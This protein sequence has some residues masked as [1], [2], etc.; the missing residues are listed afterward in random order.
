M[1]PGP[2]RSGRV[3]L[4]GPTTL[5]G[6]EL[7]DLIAESPLLPAEIRLFDDPAAA[8]LL[9][10]AA[11]EPALVQ[12]LSPESFEG[13]E[14]VFF[15]GS[16][17]FTG[18]HWP[19]ARRAGATVIDV[20][21]ALATVDSAAP[22]IPTL[23]RTL[24]PPAPVRGGLYSSPSAAA[25]ISATLAAAAAPLRVARLALVF[26][27]PVSERGQAGIDE[28]E[29]QTVHLLSMQPVTQEVFDAQVAFNLLWRY[30]AG[31]TEQLAELRAGVA[32]EVARY[33]AGRVPAPAIQLV[34]APVFYSYVFTA[35][36]ELAQAAAAGAV[37]QALSD[38]G[39]VLRRAGEAQP[40]NVSVAGERRIYLSP[41]EPDPAVRAG[42]WL[43]GAADNLRLSADNAVSIAERLRAS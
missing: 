31:S 41:V 43:W 28:L 12:P 42:F 29:S 23:D 16:P 1:S 32:A 35:Y 13:V 21:G 39:L 37:E 10:E 17:A 27:H 15:A 20:S 6:R 9:T 40:S 2:A 30:G 19:D 4:V 22:W 26:F 8:G 7:K 38:A 5:R 3:A 14:M 34:H 24:A 18:R 36:L 25:I 11:G 33:L